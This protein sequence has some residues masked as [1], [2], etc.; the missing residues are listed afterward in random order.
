MTCA[1]K[2]RATVESMTA[3]TVP[4]PVSAIICG[5]PLASSVIATL[6]VR[7]PAM[8]G[9]KVTEIEQLELT[10][11]VEP[12]ALATAKSPEAAMLVILSG[13]CPEFVN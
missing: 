2:F 9:E 10:G 12:Q 5:D 4:I 8:V 13:A 7:L 3:G 1:A 6:P 11:S